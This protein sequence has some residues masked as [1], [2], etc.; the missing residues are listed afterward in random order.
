MRNQK[1]GHLI[2]CDNRKI[3]STYIR[4]C[5]PSVVF[6][7]GLGDSGEVWGEIQD[8]ISQ[9][10]ST[11]SYDRAGIGRSEAAPIPRTLHDLAE[12]LAVLL[13]KLDVEPP[14][15][16]VGHSFGGLVARL[17]ASLYPHLIAGMVLVDAAPEYKE[18]AYERVLPSKLVAANREYYENPMLNREGID[19]VTSYKQIVDYAVPWDFPLS[20]ITSGL[21]DV[22]GEEWPSHDILQIEQTLQADFQRLST[23]SKYRIASRSGHDIHQDEPELVIEEIRAMLKAVRK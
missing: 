19:K 10:A 23:S 22:R 4:T 8:R 11:I 2:M 9:E 14:Y 1:E 21:P 6:I 17:Y 18:L 12:E 3:F 15:I 16:V 20:I 7:A 13:H 5:T